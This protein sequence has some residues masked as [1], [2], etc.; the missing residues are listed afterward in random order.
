L[1]DILPVAELGYD[2]GHVLSWLLGDGSFFFACLDCYPAHH[3]RVYDHL[4]DVVGGCS[5]TANP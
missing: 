4:V 5:A 3:L 2:V 1:N